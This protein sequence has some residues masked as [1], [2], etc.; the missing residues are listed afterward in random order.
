MVE[1]LKNILLND[2]WMLN[3]DIFGFIVQP[4]SIFGK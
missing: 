1:F 4:L 3:L 2:L